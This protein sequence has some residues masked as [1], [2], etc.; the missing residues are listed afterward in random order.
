MA[1]QLLKF[2]LVFIPALAFVRCAQIGVLTGGKRDQAPPRL[3]EAIPANRNSN[4]SS[5]RIVLKFDEFV[6]L[7]DLNNQLIVSPKL[8]TTPDI[9]ANGKTITIALKKAELSP[10]TTYRIYMGQAVAD[11]HEGNAIKNFEYVFSTG[12]YIDSLQV[13]G[14][15]T[16]AFN[17]QPVNNAV[18]GLY[19]NQVNG[20]SLPLKLVPDYL[21]KSDESGMF[22]FTN[23]PSRTFKAYA[24]NDKNKNNLYDSEVEKI[25]FLDPDLDLRSDSSVIF[26]IFQEESS[27][28]FIKK[29]LLPYYG[30]IQLV[31]NKKSK[32]EIQPLNPRVKDNLFETSPG[33]E[34]DTVS[35]YYKNVTDTLKLI[36]RDLSKQK[37]DT[38]TVQL[39]RKPP[40]GRKIKS[41]L[42]NSAGNNLSLGSQPILSFLT[43]MDIQTTDPLKINLTSR[44]DS[45]S[46]LKPVKGRWLD[47]THYELTNT[48]KEGLTYN[49]EIDTNAFFDVYGT[50]NDSINLSFKTQSHLE[51][52]KA[53]LKLLLNK[54]QAYVIQMIADN[55]RVV[56]ESF[57]D[58]PL[59]SSNAVSI[60][61]TDIAPGT[62]RVRIIF[63]NNGNKKW[64]TGNFIL[65][66]QAER[67]I[68]HSK[69][70]KVLSDWEIEEEITIKD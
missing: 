59:S 67:V 11:M 7:N 6:K 27:K 52:G 58:L 62:Y 16:D 18:I 57:V 25:G 42:L 31:L 39:P 14:T 8:K 9:E 1:K 51:F 21:A 54:K 45:S 23:L 56:R 70:I 40:V 49:L 48:L 26:K 55:D 69:P 46:A 63:D 32:I 36:F 22:N 15:V 3:I 20:D 30:L 10:N 13:K 66:R 60:D 33:Y 38:L 17:N 47:I 28:G 61:F 44:D 68:I 2:L 53:T 41:I 19:L 5:E 24:F 64:D 50:T 43:W 4:F 12:P 35:I 65:K 29:T 37:G 34:K